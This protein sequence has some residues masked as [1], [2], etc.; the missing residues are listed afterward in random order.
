MEDL[1]KLLDNIQE[2]Q[3]S[4]EAIDE[5]M[6]LAMDMDP[7]TKNY[8]RDYFEY[9]QSKKDLADAWKDTKEEYK[10]HDFD[11][12][13]EYD[14]LFEND[15]LWYITDSLQSPDSRTLMMS[16]PFACGGMINLK[17]FNYPDL[18]GFIDIEKNCWLH[19]GSY[20]PRRCEYEIKGDTCV[21]DIGGSHP[22][23]YRSLIDYLI[24]FVRHK[25]VVE[26][27]IYEYHYAATSFQWSHSAHFKLLE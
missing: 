14:V 4:K 18:I 6:Q 25:G 26:L 15:T 23:G 13:T 2:P 22:S 12:T 9:E 21:Y 7:I 5:A 11:N 3:S 24:K 16:P 19:N 20:R 10:R 17:L 1:D 27:S 8:T